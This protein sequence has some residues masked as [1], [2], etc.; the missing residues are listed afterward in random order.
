MIGT[1]RE[2]VFQSVA[3]WTNRDI[4]ILI[5][6]ELINKTLK[7]NQEDLINGLLLSRLPGCWQKHEGHNFYIDNIID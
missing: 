1:L 3:L 6:L 5:L 2:W 7:A 4:M